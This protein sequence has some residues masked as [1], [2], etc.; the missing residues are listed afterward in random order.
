MPSSVDLAY[1]YALSRARGARNFD[2]QAFFENGKHFL[3]HISNKAVELFRLT[4]QRRG[5]TA[6]RYSNLPLKASACLDRA[7][8]C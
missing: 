1:A 3:Q 6:P 8:L 2:A 4:G 7:T 5:E